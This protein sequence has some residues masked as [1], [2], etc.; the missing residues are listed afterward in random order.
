LTR[1]QPPQILPRDLRDFSPFMAIDRS[2]RS[3]NVFSCPRFNFYETKHILVPANQVDFSAAPRRSKISGNHDVAGTADMKVG[4]V[5]SAR[6]DPQ[7]EWRPVRRKST[8]GAPVQGFQDDAE[9]STGTH[10][11]NFQHMS[12]KLMWL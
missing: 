1:R 6:T 7:M 8:V 9:T 4:I 10:L 2:L 5:F 11:D 3:F 12:A